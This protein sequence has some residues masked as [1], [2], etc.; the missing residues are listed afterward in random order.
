MGDRQDQF[1]G[2]KEVSGVLAIDPVRIETYLSEAIEGFS[3]PLTISQ[4]KGGQ[5]N[6]TY[7]LDTPDAKYVLRRKP[8]GKLLKS[9]HAVDREYR[10]ISAL[11]AADFPVPRP[12][13]LCEDEEIVGT[14][15]FVMEFVEGRI[16]WELDMP[17]SNPQE[18]SAIY[19][20]ANQTIA[21]LHNFNYEQIGRIGLAASELP[22]A[23]R[24]MEPFNMGQHV[25]L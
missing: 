3:G 14:V 23:Q 12:Y 22:Y 4:F 17:D 15:F 16:F 13:V 9:A 19:E 18:R 24:T 5:S 1:T 25:L 8:P 21:D 2:T 11:Y 7:L 20:H 6:P 10:V